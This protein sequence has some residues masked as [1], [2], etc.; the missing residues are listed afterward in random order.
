MVKL[1]LF[2]L[3][4]NRKKLRKEKGSQENGDASPTEES[5]FDG[6][7][8]DIPANDTSIDDWGEDTSKEAV[9]KRMEQLGDGVKGLTYHDDLEKSVEERFNLFF[10]FVKVIF[11]FCETFFLAVAAL[12]L[13]IHVFVTI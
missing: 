5:G 12:Y 11:C 6:W 7:S 13:T 3:A 10:K 9:Q 2:C 4:V 1:A 8:D